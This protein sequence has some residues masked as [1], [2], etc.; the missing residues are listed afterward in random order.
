MEAII[1][2]HTLISCVQ[3]SA[4][5]MTFAP[6]CT[7]D[8]TVLPPP[9]ATSAV[10]FAFYP[11]KLWSMWESLRICTRSIISCFHS[12]VTTVSALHEAATPESRVVDKSGARLSQRRVYLLGSRSILL[13]TIS[14]VMAIYHHGEYMRMVI[15]FIH[16]LRTGDSGDGPQW[17]IQHRSLS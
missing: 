5:I 14:M 9:S 16:L 3:K 12:R 17:Y 8:S 15:Y 13:T 4:S 10:S 11:C 7:P 1:S 6:V 2:L